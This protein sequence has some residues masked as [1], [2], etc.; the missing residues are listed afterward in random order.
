MFSAEINLFL[1]N[2]HETTLLLNFEIVIRQKGK[3]YQNTDKDHTAVETDPKKM[4][5]MWAYLR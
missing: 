2:E 4:D 5:G 1:F 3:K